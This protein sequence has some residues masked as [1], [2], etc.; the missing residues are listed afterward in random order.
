MSWLRNER[1]DHVGDEGFLI[2]DQTTESCR[3]VFWDKEK[4]EVKTG[5]SQLGLRETSRTVPLKGRRSGIFTSLQAAETEKNV[6]HGCSEPAFLLVCVPLL[7]MLAPH[8]AAPPT[9]TDM[10]TNSLLCKKLN[11]TL[12][13]RLVF[14]GF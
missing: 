13:C 1:G 12:V 8:P 11:H 14:V 4:Q 9:Q 2:W 5:G 7:P 10:C 6:Q 3:L